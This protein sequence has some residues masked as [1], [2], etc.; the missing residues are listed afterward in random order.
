MGVGDDERGRAR[1]AREERVGGRAPP[2]HR[3]VER[4]EQL[5]A[6]RSLDGDGDPSLVELDE[7]QGERRPAGGPHLRL[8]ADGDEVPTDAVGPQGVGQHGSDAREGLDRLLHGLHLRQRLVTHPV[9]RGGGCRG[10]ADGGEVRLGAVEGVAGRRDTCGQVLEALEVNGP[11]GEDAGTATI[12]GEVAIERE[13]L[14]GADGDAAGGRHRQAPVLHGDADPGDASHQVDLADSDRAIELPRRRQGGLVTVLCGRV[15][16]GLDAV[17]RADEVALQAVAA[18]R[19]SAD[20]VQ[21]AGLQPQHEPAHHEHEKAAQHKAWAAQSH[22]VS[23]GSALS[24]P[25][26]RR[27]RP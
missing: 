8:V 17:G 18:V 12:A 9:E 2:G 5:R 13:K 19:Q 26:L 16:A 6:R 20:G 27:A 15:V 21:Q 7:H 4:R 14:A 25:R 22:S 1:V 11:V 23:I 24:R 3:R 10:R